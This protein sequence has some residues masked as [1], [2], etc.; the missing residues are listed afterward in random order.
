M[1]LIDIRGNRI[2]NSY[3]YNEGQYQSLANKLLKKI[4]KIGSVENPDRNKNLENFRVAFNCYLDLHYNRLFNRGKEFW[5]TFNIKA[6]TYKLNYPPFFQAIIY[7]L[8]EAMLDRFIISAALEQGYEIDSEIAAFKK[9]NRKKATINSL[10]DRL[11]G[12][13]VNRDLPDLPIVFSGVNADGYGVY[14]EGHVTAKYKIIKED[15][16]KNIVTINIDFGKNITRNETLHI[17]ENGIVFAS[18][19]NDDD[20]DNKPIVLVYNYV[21]DP[22]FYC[23]VKDTQDKLSCDYDINFF[24]RKDDVDILMAVCG[25]SSLYAGFNEIQKKYINGLFV[26][27]ID[28]NEFM[29]LG[30]SGILDYIFSRIINDHEFMKYENLK[31]LL[32]YFDNNYE[33]N[34]NPL[35]THKIYSSI[36][37]ICHYKREYEG[38]LERCMKYCYDN[39]EFSKKHIK[40]SDRKYLSHEAYHRLSILYNKQGDHKKV[41]AICSDALKEGW[42]GDW[43]ERIARNKKTLSNIIK[44]Q[45]TQFRKRRDYEKIIELCSDALREGL[46]G[47]WEEE[48]AHNKEAWSNKIKGQLIQLEKQG[49]HEKAIEL[50]VDAR[51]VGLQGDRGERIVALSNKIKAQSEQIGKI[52]NCEKVIKLCPDA[53]NQEL[54]EDWDEQVFREKKHSPDDIK[55]QAIKLEKD[56][57]YKELVDLCRSALENGLEGDWEYIIWKVTGNIE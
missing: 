1:F 16:N 3:R 38:F 32:N 51:K 45:M 49:D 22:R 42:H 10:S 17:P 11:V 53:L 15:K 36:I 50:C 8:A 19:G 55:N 41:I 35:N 54:Q 43:D 20:S 23:D 46:P 24:Y 7:C 12:L 30:K 39:I 33:K 40:K 44:A 5:E 14:R 52:K 47:D 29:C 9:I 31:V 4:P 34:I 13:W 28:I 25:L 48:I 26:D 37:N 27:I 18:Q 21:E 6:A 57:K 2:A 56:R